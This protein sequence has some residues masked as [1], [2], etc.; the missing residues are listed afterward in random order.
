NERFVNIKVDR[1]ERPDIDRIYQIAQQLL[2]RRTGGWPLTVFLTHDDQR[3]FFAGTY[4]P[5]QAR[6]G[7]P[8]FKDV[9][10]RVSDYYRT[11]EAEL[12]AQNALLLQAFEQLTTAPAAATTPLTSEPLAAARAQLEASFDRRFGGFSGAP[13]FP[14]APAIE[15]LLRDWY[16]SI[17]GPE[18]DTQALHMATFTLRCMADGGINDQLGGG[19]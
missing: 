5:K 16:A 3:P 17:A 1:E 6:Y 12:R 18:A 13:K 4:F 9:L 7:M 11:H 14:H 2:T 8:A 10:R 19:F 15:R